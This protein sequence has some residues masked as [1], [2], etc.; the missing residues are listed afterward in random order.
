MIMIGY[1]YT[2]EQQISI[3]QQ[4]TLLTTYDSS[5][6]KIIMK[7]QIENLN[8][9]K[10]RWSYQ[11]LKCWPIKIRSSSS[12][13]MSTCHKE[14]TF[15]FITIDCKKNYNVQPTWN[16]QYFHFDSFKHSIYIQTNTLVCYL[17]A[18]TNKKNSHLFLPSLPFLSTKE[19]KKKNCVCAANQ[20]ISREKI[21]CSRLFGSVKKFVSKMYRSTTVHVTRRND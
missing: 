16:A 4:L 1:R 12:Q 3:F 15:C 6:E 9:I 19:K 11:L 7:K 13:F 8:Y 5:G 18:L 21:V 20:M 17:H 2:I 14:R 10:I